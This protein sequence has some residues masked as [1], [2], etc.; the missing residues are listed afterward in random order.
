MRRPKDITALGFTCFHLERDGAD[1]AP[2]ELLQGVQ[3]MLAFARPR[4]PAPRRAAS[5]GSITGPRRAA[6]ALLGKVR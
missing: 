2:V 3:R 1:Y 6:L 4:T 5:S